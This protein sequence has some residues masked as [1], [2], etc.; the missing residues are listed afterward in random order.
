MQNTSVF[1]DYLTML[2]R[3]ALRVDTGKATP[4]EFAELQ[5]IKPRIIKAYQ[6]GYYERREYTALS[7]IYYHVLEEFRA[8]LHITR[9]EQSNV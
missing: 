9:R 6:A 2:T 4:A 8:L 7:S 1:T 3:Y 5:E